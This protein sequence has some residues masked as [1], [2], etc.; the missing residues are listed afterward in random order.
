MNA[1]SKVGRPKASDQKISKAR[2]IEVALPIVQRDGIEALSFR[3]LADQLGVT[4]MA[5][6]YHSGS[7]QQLLAD[8]VAVAFKDTLGQVDGATASDRVRQILTAYY[9]RALAN[10]HLLRAVLSD[11]SLMSVDLKH[12][13]GAL[14]TCTK[15][16]NDGDAG[17]VLLHLLI[18][19]THG[20]VLSAASDETDTLTIDDYLRGI[21]WVLDRARRT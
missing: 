7:R 11:P 16:L 18:D 17:S 13:T 6:T 14:G 3:T 2:I 1:R 20:F 4:P 9:T 8:L 12:V 10:A 19:Y 21:N 15:D 5:V